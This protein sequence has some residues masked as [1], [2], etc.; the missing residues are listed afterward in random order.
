MSGKKTRC[1]TSGR[2]YDG[3]RISRC[4]GCGWRSV[5]GEEIASRGEGARTG[6]LNGDGQGP[7]EVSKLSTGVIRGS[8]EGEFSKKLV[9]FAV[10]GTQIVDC[11]DDKPSRGHVR[12]KV[13]GIKSM[14][15]SSAMGRRV[16][17]R[18]VCCITLSTIMGCNSD[19]N[20]S[21]DVCV[22]ACDGN[23][24]STNRKGNITTITMD[25][26]RRQSWGKKV[27]DKRLTTV[28]DVSAGST[29]SLKLAEEIV[30]QGGVGRVA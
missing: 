5:V 22:N 28:D 25:A 1:Q 19:I 9:G 24:R 3:E 12:V 20:E 29:V 30:L 10:Y 16:S 6:S 15:F 23:I 8:E 21:G 17:R 26:T 2:R 14:L 18:V 11:K 27:F 7:Q 13:P 4:A